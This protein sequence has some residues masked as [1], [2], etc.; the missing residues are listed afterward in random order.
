MGWGLFRANR[1]AKR[2]GRRDRRSFFGLM[3]AH[4]SS[5]A[6]LRL[7]ALETRIVMSAP[8]AMPAI[9]H[10]AQPAVTTSP[11]GLSPAKINGAYGFSGAANDGA[12]QTI[13]IVDAFDDPN[14]ASDLAV[15]DQ[16][17][18]LPAPPSFQT[19]Y[20][21]GVEP[22]TNN[23]W[24][25][26]MSLDVEW[27]HAVAPGADLVLV[28]AKSD[29]NVDL[30][31]AVDVA[32]SIPSVS[33]VSMSWGSTEYA[34]EVADDAHFVTPQGHQGITFVASSGDSGTPGLWPAMSPDVLAV[35]GTALKVSGTTYVSESAWS[36]SGGGQ[37]LYE[38]EP[39]YQ[40]GVQSSGYRS[41]PDVA[42]DA[43]PATGVSVYDS[44][45]LTPGW[46]NVGGTSV[47]SPQW[48]A[49]LAIADQQR[50]QLG[51]DTIDQAQALMYQMPSGDFHDITAGAN[52]VY[53]ATP[54][55]DLVTGL[56]SPKVNLLIADLVATNPPATGS[57]AGISSSAVPTPAIGP[58]PALAL[59]PA[60][61]SV[62]QQPV[63]V[64]YA[65][66]CRP[67]RPPIAKA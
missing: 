62:P 20:A 3:G 6:R 67:A 17:F 54:G 14:I 34:G 4:S 31:A 42:Y 41:S 40:L 11:Q 58:A 65:L 39:A 29:K 1:A 33:T 28:E 61:D 32:R 48:S 59:K 12:G 52:N 38:L 46:L 43:S 18:G 13:A 26:E 63:A 53:A 27:A 9:G 16:A 64:G 7:E 47:G 50:A 44:T 8:E 10:F 55:Y 25:L 51:E 56:G 21:S 30:L 66:A 15:F 45:R 35:G 57:P 2:V 24:A 37:S 19:I 36:R 49:L 5:P 23:S 22:K 60:A